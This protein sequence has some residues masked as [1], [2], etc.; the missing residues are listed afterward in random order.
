MKNNPRR[1]DLHHHV[2]IPELA[3]ELSRRGIEWTGDKGI[4]SWNL[5]HDLERME[6]L[7]IDAAV[8]SFHPHTWWAGMDRADIE[9]WTRQGNE[10]LARVVQEN[11]RRY[12]GFASLPL[13]DVDAALRELEYAYDALG[14]DGVHLLTS[15]GGQ[16][17]GDPALEELFQELDRR[18]AVVVLHPNTKPPSVDHL[19]LS[20]PASLVEFVFDTTR[21]VANLLYSGTFE[22][23]PSIRY[24]VPHAGGTIPYLAR[25]I[26]MGA[27][28]SPVL[29]A[30]VPAGVLSYLRRL[31]YDTAVSSAPVTLT[32]LREFAGPGQIVYGSDLPHVDGAVQDSF[33]SA[34]DESPLFD[35]ADRAAINRGN[36]L[37]LFPR[38]ASDEP[39]MVAKGGATAAVV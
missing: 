34:L 18:S 1:I 23:Y 29:R 27:Q 24:I 21:T 36:A 39:S 3:A 32:A 5:S 31:Y 37:G 38:F 35:A 11:P 12:G 25:R 8:A 22:R 33:T 26:E 13:P 10:F 15:Q 28:Y 9:R 20:L 17:P 19:N 16:Y 6:S 4:P 2:V 14:L 30:R 7:G